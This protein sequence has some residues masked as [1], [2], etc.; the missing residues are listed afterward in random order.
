MSTA[1]SPE[2]PVDPMFTERWS[3][4]AFTGE[5][6]PAQALLSLIEAA[7]WAPSAMNHQPWR[8]V[9]G[10]AG[11]PGFAAIL[12]GLVPSNQAWA[13]S[14]SALIVVLSRTS[15]Q[16]ADG[17]R[18]A[19]PWHAFDAGAAWASLALQGQRTGWFTHAMAG[20]D[21]EALRAALAVP[22]EVAIHAVVAV[23]KRGDPA[24]LPEALQA[25]EQPSPR[26]PVAELAAEGR[27]RFED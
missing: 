9:Y 10:H 20:F 19:N 1:R 8:F 17:S 14:A 4:R 5:P 13:H 22:A 6:M 15:T 11:T 2:Y 21:A 12:G 26:R 16:A 7:R 3:P 24:T 18:R 27:Y 23:G 25:R